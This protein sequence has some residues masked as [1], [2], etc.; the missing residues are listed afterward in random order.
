[1]GNVR[2]PQRS[3]RRHHAEKKKQ[4]VRKA[5]PHYFPAGEEPGPRRVGLYSKTPKPCSCWMCGNPRRHFNE[6]PIQ[7]RRAGHLSEEED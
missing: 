4:W 5:L 6:S 2:A 3:I 7:E 1:M